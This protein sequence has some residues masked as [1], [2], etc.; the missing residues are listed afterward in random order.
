MLRLA[1]SYRN[2]SPVQLNVQGKEKEY[3][4]LDTVWF[5]ASSLFK[6]HPYDAPMICFATCTH[7]HRFTNVTEPCD[8]TCRA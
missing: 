3:N 8:F 4:E 5:M 1:L 7:L 6:N 2:N